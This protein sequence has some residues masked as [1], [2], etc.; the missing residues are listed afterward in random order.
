MLVHYLLTTR[1]WHLLKDHNER[2][3]DC[4][5]I[6]N[7]LAIADQGGSW[8]DRDFHCFESEPIELKMMAAFSVLEYN[9]SNGGW[10]QVLWNCFGTWSRLLDIA[11]DGYLV[12]QCI[13]QAEALPL[14]QARLAEHESDCAKFMSRSH[15]SKNV[16]F[17]EF[18]S[19]SFGQHTDWEHLFYLDGPHVHQR[20]AW[21]EQEEQLVQ[22][23]MHSRMTRWTWSQR[24][25]FWMLERS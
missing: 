13:A 14:V 2:Q 24:L 16:S 5:T 4:R 20:Y 9:M 11:C 12:T 23:L 25:W 21:L 8:Q 7:Y 22:Q 1:R 6:G 10:A 19:R 15:S 3:S 17:A 18:T